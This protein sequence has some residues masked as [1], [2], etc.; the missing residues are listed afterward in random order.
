MIVP[1]GAFED[2]EVNG[3]IGEA[4]EPL[5]ALVAELPELIDG[6]GVHRKIFILARVL[7]TRVIDAFVDIL[8]SEVVEGA[9]HVAV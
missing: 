7:T 8:R 6:A 4:K 2:V 9:P 5:Q 1:K 3:A